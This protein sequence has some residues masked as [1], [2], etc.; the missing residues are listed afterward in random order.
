M[1]A[2]EFTR[3]G[4][5]WTDI[6]DLQAWELQDL[7][8]K[9]AKALNIVDGGSWAPLNV[10]E[11]GGAGIKVTGPTIVTD[12]TVLGDITAT[13]NMHVYGAHF[14]VT[15]RAIFEQGL[16]ANGAVDI[17]AALSAVS[18]LISAGASLGAA[19]ITGALA[20]GSGASIAG[21]LTAGAASFSDLVQLNAGV[22]LGGTDSIVVVRGPMRFTNYGRILKRAINGVDQNNS[23][24]S[25]R[26][27][28]WVNFTPNVPSSGKTFLIG[29]DGE[30]LDEIGFTNRSGFTILIAHPNGN[31][32]TSLPTEHWCWC[33]R[34]FGTWV[35]LA[36]GSFHTLNVDIPSNALISTS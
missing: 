35:C 36:F 3:E 18:L 33:K 29:S 1:A 6:S 23:A 34:M 20:V 22:I 2:F 10:V 19:N 17:S 21:P 8:R 11:I 7:D 31:G 28:Q 30:E 5:I 15:P 27:N 14:N 26:E 25:P 9:T 16:I 24:F 32:L 13:Q 4:G 12:L